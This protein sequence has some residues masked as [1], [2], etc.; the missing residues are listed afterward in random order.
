M[1]KQWPLNDAKTH[2]SAVIDQ[3][4]A[5]PQLI[6][7]HGKAAAVVISIA[8]YEALTQ[9]QSAW[10]ALKPKRAILDQGETFGRLPGE[11]RP[12]SFE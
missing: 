3:A 1:S 2:L 9:Q 12:V 5:A 4:Q 10:D 6:T 11:L 7:R 8:D